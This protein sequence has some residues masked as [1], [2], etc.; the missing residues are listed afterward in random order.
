MAR[1]SAHD[2]EAILSAVDLWRTRCLLGESS[3]FS[4][5]P[6]WNQSNLGQ[7]RTHFVDNPIEG[8]DARFYEKFEQQLSVA[9][10]EV[11]SLLDARLR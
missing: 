3:V 11:K 8:T 2:L 9:T 4:D 10:T 7:L 1:T 6:L 5:R